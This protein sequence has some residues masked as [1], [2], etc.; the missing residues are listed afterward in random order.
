MSGLLFKASL[1]TDCKKHDDTGQNCTTLHY[2]SPHLILV[3]LQL[4]LC[5]SVLS[6]SPRFHRC[7]VPH[8]AWSMLC[9]EDRSPQLTGMCTI[10]SLFQCWSQPAIL[11][12][13]SLHWPPGSLPNV[14][15][16]VCCDDIRHLHHINLFAT[17]PSL[18]FTKT[19]CIYDDCD[20]YSQQMA[21]RMHT[22]L[23]NFIQARRW[24]VK[25][26]GGVRMCTW[27]ECSPSLPQILV[28]CM[29]P[30]HSPRQCAWQ[31]RTQH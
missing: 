6:S 15:T 17:S 31:Q 21:V 27:K 20:G 30:L 29:W 4:G 14:I 26:D 10:D 5:C 8:N 24:L 22:T 28:L 7:N 2:A 11:T 19:K 23:I 16:S 25:L 13:A 3:R 18:P 12:S 1:Q 9:G